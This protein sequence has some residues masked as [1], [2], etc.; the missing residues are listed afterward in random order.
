MV[1]HQEVGGDQGWHLAPYSSNRWLGTPV[2][3]VILSNLGRAW[4]GIK[5]QALR[6]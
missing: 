1:I 6:R 2:V 4:D 3:P 5:V